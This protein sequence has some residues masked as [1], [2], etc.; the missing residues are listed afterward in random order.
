VTFEEFVAAYAAHLMRLSY[1][2][3]GDRGRA[4]DAMQDALERVYLRWHRIADPVPYARQVVLN[5]TRD[6]WRRWGRR[7]RYQAEAAEIAVD[8]AT[9]FVDDWDVL[10]RALRTLPHGQRAV[11]LLRYWEDLSE[12]ETAA[13]LGCSVG[14]VKSQTHRAMQRL[15]ELLPT[16]NGALP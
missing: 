3:C 13:A 2:L 6:G 9:A 7:E 5:A 1:A 11:L 10:L 4:E 15:R 12:A 16:S 8:D 14:T